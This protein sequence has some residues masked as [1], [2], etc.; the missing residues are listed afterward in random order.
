MRRTVSRRAAEAEPHL[1]WN[2]FIDLIAVEE[3]ERLSQLQ[4]MAHL[5]FWYDSE[6]QNGGHGQY[7]ENRGTQRLGE[8]VQALQALG[9]TCQADI[10][11]KAATARSSAPALAVADEAYHACQ[12]STIEALEKHLEDHRADYIDLT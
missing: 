11:E 7:F 12:P 3:Y 8:T 9:L 1:V 6:V 4:R 10:L 5:V 2:A